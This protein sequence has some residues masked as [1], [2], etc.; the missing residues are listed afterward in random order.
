MET[1]KDILTSITLSANSPNFVDDE[2][3]LRFDISEDPSMIQ[4]LFNFEQG[5]EENT[6]AN[7][8]IELNDIETS[9]ENSFGGQDL[10]WIW[11]VDSYT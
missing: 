1:S 2:N 3:M 4:S 7:S 6:Y 9:I 8:S 5:S 10:G 11:S